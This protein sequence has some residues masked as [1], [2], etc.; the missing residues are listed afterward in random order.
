MVRNDRLIKQFL[1]LGLPTG[2]YA[3]FGSAPMY[4]H[5]LKDLGH[6]LDVVAR[7]EAWN[8]AAK[9]AEPRPAQSGTY[10]VIELFEGELEIFNGWAWG[11]WSLDE[12]IDTAEL[13][14]GIRFVTLDKVLKWKE[15]WGRPKD[16][17][18]IKIIENYL[19]KSSI[20]SDPK[21]NLVWMDLEMTGLDLDV[22]RIVEIATI[23]TNKDL[24]VVA[25]GQAIAINQNLD[26]LN[27]EVAAMHNKSGL[28][29]KIRNSK[30]TEMEAETETLE[31]IK[32]YVTENSSPL[33]GNSVWTD[34]AFLYKYFKKLNSYL[35]YRIVDVSTIKELYRRWRPNNPL[36]VKK[37]AHTT[38]E[39]IKESIEELRFY[40]SEKF[41]VI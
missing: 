21:T 11:G 29:D 32:K 35:H 28:L 31:F 16:L 41:I 22:D 15:L 34:R 17:E 2:D 20:H 14:E 9:I 26:M 13:I 36:Y 38:R 40:L 24:E 3:I 33:C 8:I 4:A 6:D 7:G 37:G 25:E 27:E 39:D 19:S 5:K 1:S 23:I 10:Q 18:H 12:L 30:V